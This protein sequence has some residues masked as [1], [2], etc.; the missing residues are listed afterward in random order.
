MKAV[1]LAQPVMAASHSCCSRC[2]VEA[3]PVR[4]PA[5]ISP[6]L[7]A[8]RGA[9]TEA[10]LLQAEVAFDGAHDAFLAPVVVAVAGHAAIAADAV[11]QQVHMLMPG[12]GMARQQ[13][14]V[15]VQAHARQIAARDLRPLGVGQQLSRRGRQRYV[16]H[17]LAQ[18]GRSLRTAPNSCA[19]SR[20]VR[21]VMLV[22]I[23]RACS[24]PRS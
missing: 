18:P 11:D 4:R 15:V 17:R 16:Q 24:L 10:Q 9:S 22:S 7:A 5:S 14:L 8:R 21:P 2:R 20:G 1:K 3:M 19:S 6:R 23:T 12:V 13:V